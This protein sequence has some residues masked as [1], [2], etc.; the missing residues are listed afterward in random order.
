MARL[1][2]ALVGA[3]AGPVRR[4]VDGRR[5][6]GGPRPSA[7]RPRG[8]ASV[9][10]ALGVLW[11]DG[12]DDLGYVLQMGRSLEGYEGYATHYSTQKCT[13]LPIQSQQHERSQTACRPDQRS[14]SS[15]RR[16]MAR[17]APSF[18]WRRARL[19]VQPPNT[20]TKFLRVSSMSV[21]DECDVQDQQTS[22]DIRFIRLSN[23]VIFQQVPTL[24]F[25]C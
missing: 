11:C 7:N 2:A 6:R 5:W 13:I 4:E 20:R 1:S 10:R 9:W 16:C 17:T 21:Q 19:L 18:L 24:E 23:E 22:T 8:G 15:T 3:P 25:V 14:A 12:W